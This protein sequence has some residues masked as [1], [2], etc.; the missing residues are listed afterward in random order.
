[1]RRPRSEGL[2]GELRAAMLGPGESEKWSALEQRVERLE[3]DMADVKTSLR[4]IDGRLNS[5][6]VSIARIEG[7]ISQSPT[8]IQLLVALIA[9]WGAGVA[10]VAALIRFAPK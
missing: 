5:I 6:E 8:W 10:I 4:S 3:E 2:N 7:K 1:M 9:T